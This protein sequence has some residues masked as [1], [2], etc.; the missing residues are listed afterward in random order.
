MPRRKE[1]EMHRLLVLPA[2]LGTLLHAAGAESLFSA[3]RNGDHSQVQ[4]LLRNG[5]DVNAAEVDGT[6][7]LM[8]AAIESDEKMLRLLVAAGAEVNAKNAMDSRRSCTPS[9]T[10]TKR[11]CCWM[12]GRTRK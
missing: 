3:I 7:A 4:R 12:P 8:H 6:T 10:F 11:A 1:I 5:A 2:V 9:P